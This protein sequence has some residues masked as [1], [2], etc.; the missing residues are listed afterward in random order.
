MMNCDKTISLL[1][2]LLE[3]EIDPKTKKE[4][5]GHLQECPPCLRFLETYKKTTQLCSNA[6]KKA[7]PPELTNRLMTFLRQRAKN[8]GEPTKGNPAPTMR[9]E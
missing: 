9:M 1:L 6:L 3:D 8:P 2:E 7:A 5:L 4:F